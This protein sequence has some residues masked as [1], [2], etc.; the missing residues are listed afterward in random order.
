MG[1]KAMKRIILSLL[2][3]LA[4]QAVHGQS[5]G[6]NYVMTTEPDLGSA[7]PPGPSPLS[8][9]V[10]IEYYDGLGRLFQRVAKGQG[11]QGEDLATLTE[12]NSRGFAGYEW[13]PVGVSANGAPTGH[14]DF[15]TA[16]AAYY[17]EGSRPYTTTEYADG[18]NP[19]VTATIRCGAA[20]KGK[21]I[22]QTHGS[23]ASGECR[24]FKLDID[25][26]TLAEDGFYGANTLRKHT[27][28][29]EDGNSTSTY[30]DRSDRVVLERRYDGTAFADT[31][32]VYD[33]RGLPVYVI[34]PEGTRRLGS[35]QACSPEVLRAYSHFY[36]YDTQGRLIES[37][38]PG[39]EP[40]Y[41]VYDKLSRLVF[42]QD[43][44]QRAG[45][46]WSVYKHDRKG[47]LA[48]EGYAA[49]PS[50]TR[51]SLQEQWGDT[52]LIATPDHEADYSLM[53][54]TGDSPGGFNALKAYFYD[55]YSHWDS[56]GIPVD[57]GYPVDTGLSA[58]GML[59]GTATLS[60]GQCM[61]SAI[62]YDDKGRIVLETERDYYT[63]DNGYARYYRYSHRGLL[64]SK[65][66]ESA[67]YAEQ[68]VIER[69]WAETRYTYD[70]G[71]RVILEE[72]RID[73]GA[74]QTVAAYA[75]DSA[76]RKTATMLGGSSEPGFHIGHVYTTGGMPES[77]IN[78]YYSEKLF[79]TSN[80]Y[81]AEA[82]AGYNGNISAYSTYSYDSRTGLRE[83]HA[84]SCAYDGLDRLVSATDSRTPDNSER[85]GYDLNGNVTSIERTFNSVTVQDMTVSRSGNRLNTIYDVSDDSR[86]GEV[87]RIM[88]GD[89][90]DAFSYDA[91]GNLTA[92][93]SR[94]IDTVL[95]HRGTNLPRRIRFDDGSYAY[96]ETRIDGVKSRR[97]EMKKLMNA[98]TGVNSSGDTVI[99]RREQWQQL[100]KRYIGD[101]EI[102]NSKRWRY[103]TSH[104]HLQ[105]F[106]GEDSLETR[107]Y[108]KDRLGSTRSVMDE[109]G[110]TVQTVGYYPCGLPYMPAGET[111]AADRLHTGKEYI[112][113]SGLGWHD[114]NA[115]MADMLLQCFTTLDPLSGD[116]PH[117]SPYSYCNNNPLR[118][119][120]PTGKFFETAWDIFNIALGANSFSDNLSSGNYGAAA[121]DGI[122]V[123][124]DVI[125]AAIPGVPGGV[126]SL[127]NSSRVADDV[128]DAANAAA[129]VEKH[130]IIPK[131]HRSHDVVKEAEKEGFN[132]NG[133][134]NIM[135]VEKYSKK[136]D[137]GRHGNHPAYNTKI[138]EELDNAAKKPGT[139]TEQIMD[140]INNTK[141][142]INS[143]PQIKINNLFKNTLPSDNTN[144]IN[145]NKNGILHISE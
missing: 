107:Y 101:F 2:A 27:V 57:A 92:D 140:V 138:K 30:T 106:S 105:M 3:V 48:V 31:Y 53:Y 104:G 39:A 10:G 37:R 80:P 42:K 82:K 36:N 47:R 137:S 72:A 43:G 58:R 84:Y 21:R 73:G 60:E 19:V 69:H 59:T 52:L 64:L 76:G 40:V 71:D 91:N 18:I 67:L 51:E 7:E 32:H 41:Y 99:V 87:P 133:P 29:D 116:F 88:S 17:G 103:Y 70:R 86:T 24:L 141:N 75:Y 120:D 110:N 143:N 111:L 112:G 55:G 34:S 12:Y 124:V 122:G 50:S 65:K 96:W 100:F 11:G 46:E 1:V 61:V 22:T 134:E 130:H 81:D 56:R 121:A 93:G 62:L 102:I 94:G 35:M 20:W 77:T 109:A 114:N 90:I 89:Y 54:A 38:A 28:T 9:R 142:T 136:L 74:W 25:G 23:N 83:D 139:A 97:A 79:Y 131:Q 132:F 115:R 85:F 119:A 63:N 113:I 145:F 14:S 5:P 45:G 128:I 95:Y 4:L 117:L 118:Y 44:N 78:R 98:V 125:A 8:G 123:V 49:L 126:S 6:H 135:E 33:E 68:T 16:S 127:I 108:I 129:K 15:K 144:P 26:R 66:T 13:L